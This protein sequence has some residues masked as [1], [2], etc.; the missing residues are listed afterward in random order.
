MLRSMYA[1]VS[2]LGA[3]LVE[4][5]VIGNNIA[6]SN[7]IGFKSGRV[8]F[9]EMLTQTLQ[10]ATR[11]TSGGRGGTN[12]QQIGLGALVGSISSNFEQGDLHST[13]VKTD[14]A[15]QG[16]GFFVL[17][18]GV[19]DTYTR[20]GAFGLDRDYFLVDPSTG[21]KVQGRMAD[22]TGAIQLGGLEDLYIDPAAVMPAQASSVLKL[23]GNLN[24]DSD[25]RG[26]QLTS[27]IF[28]ARATG[29]DAL[30]SLHGDTGTALNVGAGDSIGASGYFDGVMFDAGEFQ[31]G[32][33]DPAQGGSTLA[34]LATW[35]TSRFQAAGHNVTFAVDAATGALQATNASGAVLTDLQVTDGAKSDFNRSLRFAPSIASG[36]S[37]TT[38]ALRGSASADDLL[39]DVYN[40]DG[41][42]LNLT[43]GT[44]TLEISGTCGSDLI[45]PSQLA[46]QAGTTLGDLLGQI[47]Q[48]F[49]LTD[50]PVT[51]DSE[52]RIQVT[53]DAGL[54]NAL[55]DLTIREVGTTNMAVDTGF[56]FNATADARDAT[57]STVATTVYDSLG[58][59]HTLRFTF[60]K[61]TGQN[62]WTW[63][64]VP[65]GGEEI[66]S[67]GTGR[68]RFTA[69][70]LISSFTFDDGASAVTLRPQDASQEGAQLVSLAIDF[71]E[72]GGVGGL[73]QFAGSGTLESQ[74]DG[75]KSGDLVDFEIDQN[76]IISGRFSNDTVRTLGQIAIAGF[77]NPNGLMR[78]A[79]NMYRSSANSGDAVMGVAGDS[80]GVTLAPG[81]LESS[82]VDLAEQ[83][84]RLVV[85]QRAFQAN[86]RVITTGDQILQE[87]VS[88]LR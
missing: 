79:N 80:S 47:Q 23:F 9:Q 11:P 54:V 18:D 71:G 82:N 63:T 76:G 1:G 17:S 42:P 74:A 6:N 88:I 8:T 28:L 48:A 62:E 40:V 39:T 85:A 65:E 7:T 33:T 59:T 37:G 52:G 46:V 10:A 51:V 20:A 26:T 83:F 22:S 2:G 53:G 58:S 75:Y 13:G 84:T 36:S 64:A 31:V 25:A 61:V 55:G 86:A 12:P 38:A 68:A 4:L 21:L 81:T 60:E 67:G 87:L 57:T 27:Q 73:T 30:T 15:I 49:R 77:S 44:S 66:L 3:N 41:Q 43:A 14:L 56:N 34:D 72:V 69:D 50:R 24:A 5:D 45:T 78:E 29:T 19:T 35:L 70:G 16:K 32:A